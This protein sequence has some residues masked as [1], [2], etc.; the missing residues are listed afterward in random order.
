MQANSIPQL[1]T[2]NAASLCGVSTKTVKRWITS[3][4]L[5]AVRVGNRFRTTPEWIQ[6]MVTPAVAN[7]EREDALVVRTNGVAH[8]SN[9]ETRA[10]QVVSEIKAMLGRR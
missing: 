2:A 3:K 9:N 5:K 6:E 4:K 7:S 1:T 8:G 10:R